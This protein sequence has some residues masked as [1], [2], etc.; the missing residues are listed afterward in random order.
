MKVGKNNFRPPPKVDSSVVRIEP[1][2]PP[3]P[4]NFLEWDG[5]VRLCFGRK[6]KTLG[7]IFRQGSTLQAMETNFKT[8]QALQIGGGA[9]GGAQPAAVAAP[10]GKKQQP[11]ALA[12]QNLG[13][14]MDVSDG[15][16]DGGAGSDNDDTMDMDGARGGGAVV[17]GSTRRGKVSPG[18]KD[19]VMAL[20]QSN[21]F[22][23]LRSSKMSQEE[24]LQ[25]LAV[26][27][28][29]GIHFV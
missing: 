24:F 27:N 2:H 12:I 4:V 19:K 23:Q 29:Q 17:A 18:F 1:R 11:G 25:L 15:E 26:F 10:D 5:L 3:P 14:A 20:L 22:D 7:A 9:G 8:F 28:A 13:A 16:D 21:G 6:N